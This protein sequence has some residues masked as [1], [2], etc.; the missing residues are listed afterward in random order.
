MANG[1]KTAHRSLGGVSVTAGAISSYGLLN[2]NTEMIFSDQGSTIDYTLLCE[3]ALFGGLQHG[4]GI[5]V[6]G[7]GY[8]V[9]REPARIGDGCDC[10]VAL[11]KVDDNGGTIPPTIIAGPAAGIPQTIVIPFPSAGD[12]FPLFLSRTNVTLT[13]VRAVVRS[14]GTPSVT[15]RIG[16]SAGLEDAITDWAI[17]EMVVTNQSNGQ[18][19]TIISM[20]IPVGRQSRLLI[21]DV[22]GG[23]PTDLTVYLRGIAAS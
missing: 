14:V 19:A 22:S 21:S 3:T 5:V 8:I 12:D 16:H 17:D 7:D 9:R 23:V 2:R 11:Q 4:S 15:I 18:L 10:I 6:D 13:E 1:R 20:P